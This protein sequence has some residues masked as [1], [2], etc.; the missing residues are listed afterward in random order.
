[1]CLV[2]PGMLSISN[3]ANPQNAHTG[4]GV[5]QVGVRGVGNELE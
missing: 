1:M 2:F 5:A 3:A 4:T